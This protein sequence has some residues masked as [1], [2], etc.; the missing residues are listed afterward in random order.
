MLQDLVRSTD[1]PYLPLM[2]SVHAIPEPTAAQA[3][4]RECLHS[5]SLTVLSNQCDCAQADTGQSMIFLS[6]KQGTK[7]SSLPFST[8]THPA[9]FPLSETRRQSSKKGKPK[10]SHLTTL[11]ISFRQFPWKEKEWGFLSPPSLHFFILPD[12]G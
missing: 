1:L 11:L 7:N 5:T 12:S 8:L 2:G 9:H 10:H 6:P 4:K 3:V